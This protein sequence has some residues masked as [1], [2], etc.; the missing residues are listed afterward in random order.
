MRNKYRNRL[1][2][3][4][5]G[6]NAVGYGLMLTNSQ[7]ALKKLAINTIAGFALVGTSFIA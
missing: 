2:M 7:S 5:A 4:K 3:N 1:D 6:G